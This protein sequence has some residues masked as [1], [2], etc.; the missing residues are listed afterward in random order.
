M[1]AWILSG[2]VSRGLVDSSSEDKLVALIFDLALLAG[3]VDTHLARHSVVSLIVGILLGINTVLLRCQSLV[4]RATHV[5]TYQVRPVVYQFLLP[6]RLYTVV[7]S[8]LH[9][10]ATW[11]GMLLV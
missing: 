8:S 3:S 6:L 9:A 5:V 1:G 10:R 7:G 4:G 2:C 11:M